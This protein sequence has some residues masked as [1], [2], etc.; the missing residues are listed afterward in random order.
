MKNHFDHFDKFIYRIPALPMNIHEKEKELGYDTNALLH[1]YLQRSDITSAI[2]IASPNLYNE[3]SLYLNGEI[4]EKNNLQRYEKFVDAIL[5]YLYRMAYRATPFGSFAGLSVGKVKENNLIEPDVKNPLQK[6]VGFDTGNLVA[7]YESLLNNEDTLSAFIY[8]KNNTIYS[9]GSKY[10]YVE[11]LLDKEGKR[12]YNLATFDKNEYIDLVLSRSEN[13]LQFNDIAS[14]LVSDDITIEEARD[15]I[16]ELVKA[17]ILICELEPLVIGEEY[18]RQFIRVLENCLNNDSYKNKEGEKT[19]SS[20]LYTLNK[21]SEL[22]NKIETDADISIQAYKEINEELSNLNTRFYSK[23]NFKVDSV[24][25]TPTEASISK[26]LAED[27]IQGFEY[28]L[29]FSR[30]QESPLLDI[31]KKDFYERY[32]HQM[33]KLTEVLDPEIGIGYGT[34]DVALLNYS[35]LVDDVP[36]PARVSNNSE[37]EIRW[38]TT[39]HTF[40]FNKVLE[41]VKKNE[42]VIQLTDEEINK[43]H[44]PLNNLP[45]TVNAFVKVIYGDNDRKLI[46]FLSLGSGTALSMIGRFS[47]LNNELNDLSKN[48]A[49]YEENYY[50]HFALA[51]I[52]HLSDTKGGNITAR[53]KFRQY[54]IP[55]ITGSNQ[56]DKQTNLSV[57]DLYLFMQDGQ[58]WIYSKKL[59]KCVIPKLSNAHNFFMNTLPMY[60]FLSDYQNEVNNGGVNITLDLGRINEFFDFIPRIQYKNYIFSLAQWRF[61][62]TQL[63]GIISKSVINEQVE[64]V[65]TYLLSKNIP[66][67]FCLHEHS[68][69][70]MFFDL[71]SPTSIQLFIKMITK[72]KNIHLRESVFNN[73]KSGLVKNENGV[74]SHELLLP[75]ANKEGKENFTQKVTTPQALHD[76]FNNYLVKR[77][78]LPGEEWLYIKIYAGVDVC[79]KII[80]QLFPILFNELKLDTKWFFIRYSDPNNHIRLRLQVEKEKIGNVISTLKDLINEHIGRRYVRDI[81]ID[82]YHRELER[83]GY[84][85]I[86]H[87]EKIFYHDSQLVINLLSIIKSESN[88]YDKRWL[89]TLKVIDIYMDS[90]NLDIEEKYQFV[91]KMRDDFSREFNANK[92]QKRTITNKFQTAKHQI[93]DILNGNETRT[94]IDYCIHEFSKKLNDV[95]NV[96]YNKEDKEARLYYLSSFIHMHVIRIMKSKNRITEYVL[97]SYLEQFIRNKIGQAK[98]LVNK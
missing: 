9:L 54:H 22:F 92:I 75:L 61:A 34:L 42:T 44:A 50:Q 53:D 88:E 60:K 18:V 39:K 59:K 32:E 69:N 63:M 90:F 68:D 43:Y 12:V 1:Y 95:C 49:N 29:R 84:S 38:D 65:K 23:S 56:T 71:E 57:D 17:R 62:N 35:P 40:F 8:Y 4:S 70:E 78:F 83:Y 30:V 64:A 52:N 6:V 28:F 67:Y 37:I 3:I 72:V 91:K 46:N 93:N 5:K 7:I 13:G 51:E 16:I 14:L 10:R 25:N 36:L 24:I 2:Y 81:R 15:F 87:A 86:D 41:A 97:Y 33:I 21:C 96:S 80:L 55:Y 31:F 74:F 79:D 58:L 76:E 48:I 89:T 98:Y 27:I 47:M 94:K 66:R 45:A 11:F 19:L 20:T 82:T 77:S 26:Q 73:N 85:L